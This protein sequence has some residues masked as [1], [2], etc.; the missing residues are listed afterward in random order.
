MQGDI[1]ALEQEFE[2]CIGHQVAAGTDRDG[3]DVGL[4]W[5]VGICIDPAY[6]QGPVLQRSRR[7]ALAEHQLDLA[8]LHQGRGI[9][10]FCPR[11]PAV[12]PR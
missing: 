3:S 2:R 10:R 8:Q 11:L 7:G 5:V 9:I 6:A 1:R 12:A 4:W